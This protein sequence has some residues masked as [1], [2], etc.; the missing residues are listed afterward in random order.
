MWNGNFK[1]FIFS[2]GRKRSKSGANRGLW[3]QSLN[4]MMMK[5]H[6]TKDNQHSPPIHSLLLFFFFQQFLFYMLLLL[7]HTSIF[8]HYSC[9]LISILLCKYF[10]FTSSYCWPLVSELN[11]PDT[12]NSVLHWKTNQ[13]FI[14]SFTFYFIY[15]KSTNH[16]QLF[17]I[18]SELTDTVMMKRCLFWQFPRCTWTQ[19]L[20]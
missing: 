2:Q 7:Q 5:S 14:F 10:N 8:C 12:V 9:I 3:S 18:L 13:P 16:L 17:Q 19:C 15:H 11:K 1:E 20:K 4:V 6:L